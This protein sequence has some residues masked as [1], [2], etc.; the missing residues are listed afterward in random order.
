M[1]KS[2]SQQHKSHWFNYAIVILLGIILAILLFIVFFNND[3]E[4]RN[5][6]MP[7][8]KSSDTT[9]FSQQSSTVE[10]ASDQLKDEYPYGVDVTNN[11]T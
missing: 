5:E 11:Q 2:I 8:Q 6:T 7:S 1:N 3:P 9:V 4:P 10:P